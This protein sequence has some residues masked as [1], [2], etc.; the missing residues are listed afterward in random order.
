MVVIKHDYDEFWSSFNQL[1][2]FKKTLDPRYTADELKLVLMKWW[3]FDRRHDLIAT[4][5]GRGINA[6]ALGIDIADPARGEITEFEVKVDF[7]DMKAD[8]DKPKHKRYL[9][10]KSGLIPDYFYY[11]VPETLESRA[12]RW[13][14]DTNCPYGLIVYC[15]CSQALYRYKTCPKLCSSLEKRAELFR[16]LCCRASSQLISNNQDYLVER[17]KTKEMVKELLKTKFI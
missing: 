6:D 15:R 14:E 13:L 16:Q 12:K 10:T 3:R 8:R 7:E 4:E 5:V 11:V 9:I 2:L 1:D 17:D